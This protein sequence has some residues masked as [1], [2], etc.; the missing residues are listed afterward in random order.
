MTEETKVSVNDIKAAQAVD[1][2]KREE[3]NSITLSTGV[4][5]RAKKA[6][7]LVMIRVMAAFPRPKP[8]TWFNPTM[9]R[10]MENPQDPDYMDKLQAY[11]ME[12]SSAMLSAMIMLGTELEELPKGFEG[13]H[14]ITKKGET[15]WPEWIEEY[16]LLGIPMHAQNES[17]RYL[18]WVMFKAVE[19]ENDLDKIKEVVGK[20]S[21]IREDAVQTA[22]QFPGSN[23]AD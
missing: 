7:P 15:I 17:W 1:D 2:A 9:G 10:E 11:Q 14:P 8:P 13:P 18:T 23:E 16:S 12:M 5:L 19:D 3:T 21:G 4:K 6:N 22:E 20:L